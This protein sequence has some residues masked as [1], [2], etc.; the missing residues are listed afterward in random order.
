V[1]LDA[2]SF[3]ADP[4]SAYRRLA[5]RVIEMALRDIEFPGRPGGD[6]DS[7]IR[8]LVGAPMLYHWCDLAGI[9]VKRVIAC[10]ERARLKSIPVSKPPTTLSAPH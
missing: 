5:A 10:G 8:F 1:S 9:D 3:H 2:S 4:L 7:A 6:R